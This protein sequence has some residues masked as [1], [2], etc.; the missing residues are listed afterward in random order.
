MIQLISASVRYIVAQCSREIYSTI[1]KDLRIPLPARN[2][3]IGHTPIEQITRSKIRINVDQDSCRTL[4][5]AGVACNRVPVVKMWEDSGVES[6]PP[7]TIY[8][9]SHRAI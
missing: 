2:R 3:D 9:Q 5:L 6:Y 8:L 7:P 4:P 1:R